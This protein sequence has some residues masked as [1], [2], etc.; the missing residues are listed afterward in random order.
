MRSWGVVTHGYIAEEP[1]DE[2]V[3]E[4]YVQNYF[5]TYYNP[6]QVHQDQ[7][8]EDAD[9]DEENDQSVIHL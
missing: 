6:N 8:E 1:D 3:G 4:D 9:V 7:P 5:G 2:L